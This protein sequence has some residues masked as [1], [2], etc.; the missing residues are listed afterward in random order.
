MRI[1]WS[2]FGITEGR[3]KIG[4]NVA[5][6]N[7]NGAYLRKFTMP[8][9]PLTDPQAAVRAAFAAFQQQWRLLSLAE[10]NAWS[11][12][13]PDFPYTNSMGET[14]LYTGQQLF[15]KL[16]QS[17]QTYD[18]ALPILTAPPA[19]PAGDGATLA[20]FTATQI[21]NAIATMTVTLSIAPTTDYAMIIFAT[22]PMSS[23]ISRPEKSRFRKVFWTI[24]AGT[25]LQDIAAGY[26]AVYGTSLPAD[27]RVFVRAEWLHIASGKRWFAGQL[28]QQIA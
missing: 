24:G 18:P 27:S 11:A 2:G 17:R 13:A 12:A 22:P 15:N 23:G 4:G 21:S 14:Q 28:S 26:E 5:G 16:N 19:P 20:A 9:N 25:A 1:K 7:A 6:R 8:V 10:Q 3:G